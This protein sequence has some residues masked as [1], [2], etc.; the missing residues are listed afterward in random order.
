MKA[1][2]TNKYELTEFQDLGRPETVEVWAF[3]HFFVGI[4]A[5][6]GHFP[7]QRPRFCVVQTRAFA[8]K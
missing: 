6:I 4:R 8:Q 1:D 7:T 5:P 2:P 3:T